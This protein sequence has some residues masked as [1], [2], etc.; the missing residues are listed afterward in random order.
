MA[1]L[2]KFEA[3]DIVIDYEDII[4]KNSQ[5]LADNIQKDAKRLWG[6]KSPYAKD[7]TY[8]IKTAKNG[9]KY[10]IVYNKEHYRL[11]HLLEHGHVVRNC[12][13]TKRTAPKEHIGNNF[14]LQ[15]TKFINEMNKC[16]YTYT[17][18]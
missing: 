3:L 9:K 5:E 10:G 13:K 4:I 2:E 8:K 7:W 17:K 15:K 12:K 16:K 6:S 18:G 1:D 14:K 11:T